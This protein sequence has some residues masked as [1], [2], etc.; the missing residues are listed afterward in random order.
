LF[1]GDVGVK[2]GMSELTREYVDA[3]WKL[4][5][6]ILNAVLFLLIG[7]EVLTVAFSLDALI[8]GLLSIVLSLLARLTSVAV[9][10]L[11]LRPFRDFS[12]GIVP[13]MTWGGLKGGISVALA[14]SLPDNEYKPIILTATYV[15]VVFSIIVQ[16]LT[17]APLAKRL[18]REPES[19]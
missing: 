14:L 11:I 13:I 4:I 19:M 17:I 5:D 12:R 15:V 3:F 1:I 7:I 6:E 8:A 18:G 10:I 2:Y 9:P 16:G